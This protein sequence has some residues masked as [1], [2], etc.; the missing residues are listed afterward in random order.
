[1]EKVTKQKYLVHRLKIWESSYMI[2]VNESNVLNNSSTYWTL[3][4]LYYVPGTVVGGGYLARE[5]KNNQSP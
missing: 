4:I 5:E 2:K 3:L 1:M